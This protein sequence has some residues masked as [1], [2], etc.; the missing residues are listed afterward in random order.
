MV[1]RLLGDESARGSSASQEVY[2][3]PYA[4]FLGGVGGGTAFVVSGRNGG[5]DERSHDS[6]RSGD[7]ELNADPR[8]FSVAGNRQA[9]L[10]TMP[11]GA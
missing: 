10:R 7:R 3:V 2:G 5:A 1:D 4:G 6:R 8:Q 11:S 9:D